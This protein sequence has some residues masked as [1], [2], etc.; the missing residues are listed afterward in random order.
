MSMIT[1]QEKKF[2]EM[3]LKI[4]YAIIES[5][6]GYADIDD[7]SFSRNDLYELAIKL[8]FDDFNPYM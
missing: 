1:E 5:Q 3:L 4:G 7:E 6:G 2:I 8:G